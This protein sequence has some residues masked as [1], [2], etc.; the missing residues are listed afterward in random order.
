MPSE[1]WSPFALIESHHLLQALY[2]LHKLGIMPKLQSPTTAVDLAREHQLDPTMLEVALDY[3]A[4][5]SNLIQRIDGAYQHTEEYNTLARFYLDQYI[6]AYGPN[7][8]NL[9]TIL[10]EPKRAG[11]FI[12]RQAHAGAWVGLSTPGLELLPGIVNQLQLTNL[13]DMGCGPGSLL[14]DIAKD[15]PDF[16]GWGVDINPDMIEN[17]EERAQEA[18]F[19]NRLNFFTGDCGDPTKMVPADLVPQIQALTGMSLANEFFGEGDSQAIAWLS[20][21]QK[22][23]PG[24]ALILVDYYGRLGKQTQ[25]GPHHLLLQDFVQAISGQ[26]VPPAS[27]K[28]WEHIYETAGCDVLHVVEDDE[29][30]FFVHI[31][32][33][34]EQ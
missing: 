28:E 21:L 4:M 19:S 33:L 27:L 11:S 29:A 7:A 12:N 25:P 9:E 32:R 1:T 22:T 23:F 31:L 13:L 8:A 5:R 30:T 17:A 15:N 34:R 10:K 2:T 3:L 14:L 18:D 20:A 16:K 6:G 24:R 26:G